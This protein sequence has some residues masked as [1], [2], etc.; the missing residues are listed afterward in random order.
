MRT[1]PLGAAGAAVP[2]VC[3]E[4]QLLPNNLATQ[5]GWLATGNM[6]CVLQQWDAPATVLLCWPQLRTGT[7]PNM[8]AGW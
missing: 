5:A 7:A 6:Q 4:H 3:N 8:L 1:A 2:A